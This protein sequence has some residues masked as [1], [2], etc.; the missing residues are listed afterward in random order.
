LEAQIGSIQSLELIPDYSDGTTSFHKFTTWEGQASASAIIKLEVIP[1]SAA[2]AIAQAFAQNPTTVKIDAV[3]TKSI[4]TPISVESV[5]KIEDGVI[6]VYAIA[7]DESLLNIDQKHSAR[8]KVNVGAANASSSYFSFRKYDAVF[9]LGTTDITLNSAKCTCQV[10]PVSDW[11]VYQWGVCYST[12]QTPTLSDTR[13]IATSASVLNQE[14]TFTGLT[15]DTDYY[16]R[17]FVRYN[18]DF[19]YFGETT[20][21]TTLSIIPHPTDYIENGTNLGKS[22]VIKMDDEYPGTYL[23]WAP[24]NCGFEATGEVSGQHDH[25]MGLLYQ[26][27]YGDSSLSYGSNAVAVYYDDEVSSWPSSEVI[28]GTTT[29]KWNNDNGPCPTGWR[30]PTPEEYD[31]LT[32]GLNGETGW[33]RNASYAGNSGYEGAEFFG[34]NTDKTAGKGVFFPAV[35]GRAAYNGIPVGFGDECSCWT[36]KPHANESIY[37]HYARFNENY[38]EFSHGFRALG[39]SVRC[40]K[41]AQ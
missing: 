5:E 36:S 30:L 10:N 38:I 26:W 2:D 20:S 40:V 7:T 35:G 15:E 28:T 34:K 21:F 39:Y 24:V 22:I 33:V 41:D 11:T 14:F 32:S 13:I 29:D 23:H 4:F 18:N 1:A 37:S 17:P 31:I 25:R 6:L 3:Q 12:H 19:I 16:Y 27:G 9:S 8:V